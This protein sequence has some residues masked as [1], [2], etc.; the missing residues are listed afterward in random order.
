MIKTSALLLYENLMYMCENPKTIAGFE[1]LRVPRGHEGRQRP[2]TSGQIGFY[3]VGT[4]RRSCCGL[5][6]VVSTLVA[7]SSIIITGGSNPG[8]SMM[9]SFW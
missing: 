6:L 8:S 2:M 9:F 4:I 3:Y 5:G 7:V 1:A